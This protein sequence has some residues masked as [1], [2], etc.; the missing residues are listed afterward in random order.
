MDEEADNC[1][2][3]ELG[4][5]VYVGMVRGESGRDHWQ[6]GPFWP[7]CPCPCMAGAKSVRLEWLIVSRMATVSTTVG[8]V[9]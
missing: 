8:G 5:L 1:P 2:C 6:L 3:V 9:N 4:V 7:T